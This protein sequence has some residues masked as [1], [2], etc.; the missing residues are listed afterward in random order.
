[1]LAFLFPIRYPVTNRSA[2]AKT[3]RISLTM[4]TTTTKSKP[5]ADVGL[6][7][8]SIPR[9]MRPLSCYWPFPSLRQ[10]RKTPPP[11]RRTT[12][13]MLSQRRLP[14]KRSRCAIHW[15]TIRTPR[16]RAENS[17]NSIAPS[18]TATWLKVDGR[19]PRLR[20]DPATRYARNAFLD[21]DQRSCSPRYACVV[22]TAGTRALARSSAISSWCRPE[23]RM[24]T[25]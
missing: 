4:E 16:L 11:R 17:L 2:L 6:R 18:A 8:A 13:F 12:P 21:I 7:H 22:Q 23:S 3:T 15:R 14:G 24:T 5:R 25:G 19:P 20:A 1:M 10:R 9:F